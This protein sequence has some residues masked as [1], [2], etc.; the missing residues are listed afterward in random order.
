MSP[1]EMHSVMQRARL[2]QPAWAARGM[3]A[4]C[5]LLGE[6]GRVL[7]N[8]C[9]EVAQAISR[10][11]RKPM[12]DALG[13]D[14]MVTLEHLRYCET[15]AERVLRPRKMRKPSIFFRRTRFERSYEPHGV[16]LV[17][18]PVN[19]PL[20]LAMI[21][22]TTALA[23]G[24]AVLLKCSERTP[25][26]AAAIERLFREAGFPP[27]VVQVLYG[28]PEQ[29]EALLEQRPDIVFFTGSCRN[30]RA[31]AERAAKQLIPCVLELGGKDAALVFADCN[32]PRAVEGITYGAFINS[33][34]ACIAPK[35]VYVQETIYDEFLKGLQSRV[36]RLRVEDSLDADVVALPAEERSGLPAQVADAL[37]RG[38]RLLWPDSV[39]AGC[40]RP[41]ILIDVPR[42]AQI[43]QEE[44][45][46]PVLCVGSFKTEEEAI[47]LAN[48]S[49]FALSS[50]VWTADHARGERVAA[51][52][53][54]GS[55]AIN[56]VI[57]QIAN[58]YAPFGGNRASGYGRY[59]G[60]EGLL[61]FSRAKTVMRAHAK[62]E[63][64]IQWFPLKAKTSKDVVAV[65]RFRHAR[66]GLLGWLG[67]ILL[68]LA[69]AALLPAAVP[70]ELLIAPAPPPEA[71]ALDITVKLPAGAHGDVAYL[72]FPSAKGFPGSVRDA[73]QY[74][75]VPIPAGSQM[76]HVEAKLPPGTYAVSVYEDLNG[77]HKLDH[78]LIGIPREP[79]G[80]SNNPRPRMGPPRFEDCSFHLGSN[81]QSITITLVQS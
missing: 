61:A 17:I 13:G 22:A 32:L 74:G 37:A 46:G 12:L 49:E 3:R 31:V 1:E 72:I 27:D 64:E 55:C 62:A 63:R 47:A 10:E 26:T 9:E 34:R 14:V 57:R 81:P 70:A 52:M 40:G 2:V 54:A 71:V 80:A 18:A 50:S 7:S 59:H 11:V 69:L 21:P 29:G 8:S 79:V 77:N 76:V 51:Q 4:R 60:E 58:P 39:A 78:N 36:T 42:D 30:G 67:R 20:Q 33:G 41:T 24:N 53:A 38:A 75:Y 56:D 66:R 35:R 68:P 73:L 5:A 25:E 28:G 15:E 23:A 16:A 6:L 48:D 44:S 65:L 19:Y 45:F 43:L